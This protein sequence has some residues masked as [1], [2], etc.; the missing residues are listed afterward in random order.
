MSV[1]SPIID[2]TRLN[3]FLQFSAADRGVENMPE[4]RLDLRQQS[5]L[6]L[7]KPFIINN[8]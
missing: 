2:E 4:L 8:Q 1:S 5:R 3:S 6:I 7:T